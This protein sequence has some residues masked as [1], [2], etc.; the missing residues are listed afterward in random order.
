MIKIMA[1]LIDALKRKAD[2]NEIRQ[3]IKGGCFSTGANVNAHEEGYSVL[4]HAVKNHASKEVVAYLIMKGARIDDVSTNEE[5]KEIATHK[6]ALMLAVCDE[7][8]DL[9]TTLI[10]QGHASLEIKSS[11]GKTALLYAVQ[12]GHT[13]IVNALLVKNANINAM[14]NDGWT[15]LMY[16]AVNGHTDIVK[17]LLANGANINAK[18]NNGLQ[19]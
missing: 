19:L 1:R 18:N 16:A 9:V 12:D 14:D 15:A 8:T 10:D 13:D 17:V 3:L 2:I 4:M 7:N 5:T 6:T 11:S